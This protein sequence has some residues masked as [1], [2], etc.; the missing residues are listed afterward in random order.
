MSDLFHRK[1][2]LGAIAQP[3][4]FHDPGAMTTGKFPC[5]VGAA[6][7]YHQ[8]FIRKCHAGKTS[9]QLGCSI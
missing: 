9:L 1:L 4:L 2:L 8:D 3:G 7:I 5:A 6:R